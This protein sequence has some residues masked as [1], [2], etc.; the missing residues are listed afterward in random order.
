MAVTAHNGYL[1][2]LQ[3]LLV[4]KTKWLFIKSFYPVDKTGDR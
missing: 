1:N 4:I 3:N 2:T